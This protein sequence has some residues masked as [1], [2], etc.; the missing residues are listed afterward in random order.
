MNYTKGEWK[1]EWSSSGNRMH[2]IM[3]RDK[4]IAFMDF[5]VPEKEEEAN[6]NM[7]AAAPRLYEALRMIMEWVEVGHINDEAK[8]E[9]YQALA[10][11][12]GK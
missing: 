4:R 10:K 12:E 2:Y 8:E 6:A 1:V 3:A 5:I 7:I 11:A 9:A